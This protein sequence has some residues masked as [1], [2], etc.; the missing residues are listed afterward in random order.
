M[1]FARFTDDD[2]GDLI[3]YLK[4]V[5]PVDR[6]SVPISVGPV[7]R[8]LLLA[9]K[10]QLSADL[11]DHTR[12]RPDVVKPGVTV[13]YG[14]YLAAGCTGCHGPN[15]SGGKIDIGP[16]DWPQARNL[17]PVGDL[18][19]WTEADFL[20]ALRT[21]IRPDGTRLSEVMPTAFGQMND[22]ELKA[23]WAYLQTLPPAATGIR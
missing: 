8:A 15:L 21:Q 6:D 12:V 5:P 23:L 7:A 11:I 17:T 13:A 4:S 1:N 10:I 3:S 9:G 22:T 14:R 20:K 16:P 18:A 19:K 2:M